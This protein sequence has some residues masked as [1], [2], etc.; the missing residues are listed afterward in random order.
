MLADAAL[1][2]A[3]HGTEDMIVTRAG[4]IQALISFVEEN[5][6][7]PEEEEVKQARAA[8]SAGKDAQDSATSTSGAPSSS[9]SQAAAPPPPSTQPVAKEHR[10]E[11]QYAFRGS[12]SACMRVRVC[13]CA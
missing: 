13:V 12:E 1:S 9:S 10:D 11:L 4:V 6:R 5:Y 8:S 3:R 2:F 7:L